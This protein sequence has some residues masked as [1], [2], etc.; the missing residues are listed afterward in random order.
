MSG[1]NINDHGNV[2]NNSAPQETQT[3]PATNPQQDNAYTHTAHTL[4]Y[5]LFRCCHSGR[6]GDMVPEDGGGASGLRLMF[7][8]RTVESE[9][10]V[11]N[12]SGG[13][14]GVAEAPPSEAGTTSAA[15]F[16][17]HTGPEWNINERYLP[18]R[19][20]RFTSHMNSD[21]SPYTPTT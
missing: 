5:V 3:P 4:Q 11:M 2:G 13:N 15:I 21:R 7:Q 14:A 8:N 12:V 1:S 20:G 9:E 6:M 10:H 17:S 18:M 16:T 19:L